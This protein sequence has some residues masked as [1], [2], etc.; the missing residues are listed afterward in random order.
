MPTSEDIEEI[1]V[2]FNYNNVNKQS[3]LIID[4]IQI[5]NDKHSNIDLVDAV[6]NG[7]TLLSLFPLN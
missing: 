2:V 5:K 4:G 3:N 6:S 1:G 7:F